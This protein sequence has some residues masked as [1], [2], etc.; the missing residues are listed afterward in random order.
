MIYTNSLSS[1]RES[2]VLN[3]HSER[4][5]TL[6]EIMMVIVIISIVSL[7][8]VYLMTALFNTTIL[9]GQQL[10]QQATTSTTS[11]FVSARVGNAIEVGTASGATV[12]PVS[13]AGDQ[14]FAK[15]STE[16]IRVFYVADT[17]AA[18]N[19]QLREATAPLN[20]CNSI[21]PVRG[22]NQTVTPHG[23]CF[24]PCT[25]AAADDALYD[26][27]LDNPTYSRVAF[28][29]DY[30]SLSN[31]GGNI[32][33]ANQPFTYL[34]A[35]NQ[36]ITDFPAKA[37]SSYYPLQPASELAEV[38]AISFNLGIGGAPP[39]TT[40]LVSARQWSQQTFLNVRQSCC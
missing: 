19:A 33:A 22:P 31:G 20:D 40:P 28:L 27:V 12:N 37:D 6:V 35:A 15:T 9:A 17:S 24:A 4:G 10:N 23:N 25:H 11:S 29:V 21:T 3:R 2:L 1:L 8:I 18:G 16:C 30:A 26:P 38:K 39:E 5:T 14:F 36:P 34:D 13:I 7:G 32:T